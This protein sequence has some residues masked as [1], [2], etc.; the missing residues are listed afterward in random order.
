MSLDLSAAFDCVN[1]NILLDRLDSDFG[2][3]GTCSSWLRSFLQGRHQFV[4]YNYQTS[5]PLQLMT[6]VPQGS[7]LAPLLFTAHFSPIS[8]LISSFKVSYHSYADDTTLYLALGNNLQESLDLLNSCSTALTNWFL[9]N[10]L[11]LNASKSDCLFVGT[12]NQL[13]LI[14]NLTPT[15]KVN[16]EEVQ[17]SASLKLLGVTFDSQLNFNSHVSSVCQSANFH[18][19]ALKHIRNFISVDTACIVACSLIG[20]RLDYCNLLFTGITDYNITRLQK[21]QKVIAKIVLNDFTSPAN[22]LLSKLHWLPITSRIE[23][24]NLLLTYKALA[25]KEPSYLS[26]LQQPYNSVRSLSSSDKFLLNVPFCKTVAFRPGPLPPMLLN[27][28]IAF[29]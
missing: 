4:H 13:K 11:Q 17:P 12:K 7:V 27:S 2:V 19:R 24:K 10:N 21:V 14:S 26:N 15:I 18:A 23:Y 20:S 1:P 9:F 29:L 22:E 16:D 6:G 28:S 5:S 8:R 25:A 3:A